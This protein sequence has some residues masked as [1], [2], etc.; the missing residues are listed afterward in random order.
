MRT[1]EGTY[2]CDVTLVGDS[3][4]TASDAATLSVAYFDSI[5]FDISTNP[6]TEGESETIVC[7]INA[8]PDP[9][10]IL[11]KDE[12]VIKTNTST[13]L[14]Y[15]ISSVARGDEGNY[16]CEASNIAGSGT[17]QVK[18]LNVH[19]NYSCD[20]EPCKNGGTCSVVEGGYN[21]RCTDNF[22]GLNCNKGVDKRSVENRKQDTYMEYMADI[23]TG[24][25]NQ[26]YQDLQ[27]K[28]NAY[29]N[30]KPGNKY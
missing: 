8:N 1:A 18:L 22:I 27:H 19:C 10:I 9:V 23:P 25:D 15:S 3:P 5:M 14:M 26:T 11:Y 7:S 24:N 30:V 4:S 20:C 12:T 16:K 17:S 28:E 21:C 13:H 6:V 2:E 29:V